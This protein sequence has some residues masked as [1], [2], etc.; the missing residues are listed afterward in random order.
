LKII[1]VNANVSGASFMGTAPTAFLQWLS[2]VLQSFSVVDFVLSIAA[3]ASLAA[4][5]VS[6]SKLESTEAAWRASANKLESTE[7]ELNQY[8][9]KLSKL[10]EEHRR[11]HNEMRQK[12]KAAQAKQE[13]LITLAEQSGSSKVEA[14]LPVIDRILE[15]VRIWLSTIEEEEA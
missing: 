1:K 11:K 9:S 5:R 15:G 7:V 2:S 6:A 3:I 10:Q 14:A 4:W 8:R 12:L 13:E